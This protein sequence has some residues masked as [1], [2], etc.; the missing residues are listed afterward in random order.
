MIEESLP[1]ATK[2]IEKP[3]SNVTLEEDPSKLSV[4]PP[5]DFESSKDPA[6]LS[7]VSPTRVPTLA[8]KSDT[9]KLQKIKAI[10]GMSITK[11]NKEIGNQTVS[12]PKQSPTR[13]QL[14]NEPVYQNKLHDSSQGTLDDQ[15]SI[16]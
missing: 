14:T 11:L 9:D 5:R 1:L 4:L 3:Y 13:S 15:G 10:D 8:M 7:I 12:P 6:S 2:I 16:Y